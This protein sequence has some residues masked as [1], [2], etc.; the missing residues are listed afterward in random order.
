[1]KEI[2]DRDLPI[3]ARGLGNR[4]D[5]I[6]HFKS[7]RRDY[8]AEIIDDIMP[9]ETITVYRRAMEAICAGSALA[10]DTGKLGKAFK[11]MKL[12]GAYWRGDHRNAHAAAHLRHGLGQ[13]EADLKAHLCGSR[14][15]RSATTARSAARWTSSTC[16]KRAGHGVLA[17]QGLDALAHARG[18]HAPPLDAAGYVEVRTPQVLDRS[19]L[20]EVGP[21]GEVSREHVRL[22]DGGGETLG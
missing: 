2:V 12:A 19:L 16:R 21:L 8:K 7:H 3:N 20:G 5:A 13:R 15:P 4:D 1:M 14:R 10:V 6:A 11:L 17:P 22:R 9:G 18:L